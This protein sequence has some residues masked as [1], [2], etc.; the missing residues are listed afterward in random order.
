MYICPP[1]NFHA[2]KFPLRGPNFC[3]NEVPAKVLY[4]GT[5]HLPSYR[6]LIPRPQ[7]EFKSRA[8]TETLRPEC[9]NLARANDMYMGGGVEVGVPE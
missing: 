2:K 9:L 1:I 4:L 3:L 5:G 7:S 6:D 8:T